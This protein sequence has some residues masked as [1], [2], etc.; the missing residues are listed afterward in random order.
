MRD[1]EYGARNFRGSIS[2]T[3]Q[4]NIIVGSAV[5][6]HNVLELACGAADT[7]RLITTSDAKNL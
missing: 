6:A 5:Q 2:G 4:D 1:M 7:E 3:L